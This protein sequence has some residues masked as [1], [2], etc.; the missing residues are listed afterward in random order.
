[1]LD[2]PS[3]N[4]KTDPAKIAN[5]IKNK[6]F[7]EFIIS[8]DQI[9]Q[10]A[11]KILQYAAN[12]D[13][14]FISIEIIKELFPEDIEL[15]S[16]ALKKLELLS[17][18]SIIHDKNNNAG[19]RIHR[20]LQKNVQNLVNHHPE[21]TISAQKLTDNLL[22]TLDKIFPEV[23][24]KPNIEWQM[25]GSLQAHLEKLLKTKPQVATEKNIFN[26]ANLYYKLARYHLRANINYQLALE[27]AQTALKHR[28]SLCKNNHPDLANAFNTVGIIYRRLGNTKEGLKYSQEGLKI[29]QKAYSTDH[30]DIADS[31]KHVGIA[32][33]QQGEMQ[34][35]LRYLEIGLNMN[36]RLYS[37][38]NYEIARF[39]N[40]IGACYLD[41]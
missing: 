3:A 1:M 29:R 40:A 19:F 18:I 28:K 4:S 23:K 16:K 26:L 11:W 17:L 15:S 35:G 37:S 30:P 5:K 27:Y 25:A 13:P 8:T 12:L 20:K 24:H 33:I 9:K 41:L 21:H 32:H 14:D 22:G 31:L 2:N 34:Q 38:D 6:L 10:Q 36:K 39:L 7:H